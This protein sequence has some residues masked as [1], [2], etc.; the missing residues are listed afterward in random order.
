MEWLSDSVYTPYVSPKVTRTCSASSNTRQALAH[1]RPNADPLLSTTRLTAPLFP[2]STK[3]LTTSTSRTLRCT[4]YR[5]SLGASGES[6]RLAHTTTLCPSWLSS[7]E[8]EHHLRPRIA[9]LPPSRAP[10]PLLRLLNVEL[11]GSAALV[12][13]KV[14][15]ATSQAVTI[16][17]PALLRAKLRYNKNY[18]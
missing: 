7:G 6:H 4:P 14:Y 16:G 5:F 13:R 18:L 3:P 10:E 12:I 11:D 2:N 8:A 17:T 9:L 15:P 1:A